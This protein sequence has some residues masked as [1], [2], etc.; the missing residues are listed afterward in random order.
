MNSGLIRKSAV[1]KFALDARG[2]RIAT[3]R[4]RG[5]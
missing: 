4:V 2:E 3:V 1:K 5:Y